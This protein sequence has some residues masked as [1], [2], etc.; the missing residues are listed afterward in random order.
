M[1]ENPVE[2]TQEEQQ[3]DLR[4]VQLCIFEIE[5][6]QFAVDILQ[7]QEIIKPTEITKIPST[8]K[9]LLGVINLRGTIIPIIQIQSFIGLE[10]LKD[11]EEG[12]YLIVKDGNL[13]LGITVVKVINMVIVPEKNVTIYEESNPLRSGKYI[14]GHSIVYDKMIYLI[15]LHRLIRETKAAI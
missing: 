11:Y 8:P 4:T 6:E 13:V 9:F 2:T 1:E 10:S 12:E 14:L 7:V 15:D 3:E 5:R